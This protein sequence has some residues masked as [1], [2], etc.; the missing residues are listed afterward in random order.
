VCVCVCGCL[1]DDESAV[2]SMG[3]SSVDDS[4][5]TGTS[6]SSAVGAPDMLQ[7]SERAASLIQN[8]FRRYQRSI[9]RSSLAPSNSAATETLPASI[10]MGINSSERES[11]SSSC[12]ESDSDVADIWAAAAMQASRGLNYDTPARVEAT[13]YHAKFESRHSDNMGAVGGAAN[14]VSALGLESQCR[15]IDSV[16]LV[17]DY[18]SDGNLPDITETTEHDEESFFDH[19]ENEEEEKEEEEEEEKKGRAKFLWG[20]AAAAGVFV[21][22]SLVNGMLGGPP[23]DEDDAIGVAVIVKGGGTGAS[24]AGAGTGGGAGAGG[25]S[26]AQ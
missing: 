8:R 3:G 4:S 16:F 25:A 7:F 24:G 11:S 26:A 23:V 6:S 21:G 9:L 20:V 22:A 15:A 1:S 5:R 17:E 18:E 12:D 2:G 14:V 10:A 13:E 19:S